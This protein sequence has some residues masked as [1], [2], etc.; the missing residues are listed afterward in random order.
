[1]PRDSGSCLHRPK[2]AWLL[3]SNR[4][5]APYD[6]LM[7][8]YR[9]FLGI[10]VLL[11]IALVGVHNHQQDTG[12]AMEGVL[13][14]HG[15]DVA[16]SCQIASDCQV[17]VNH[18]RSLNRDRVDEIVTSVVDS[19]RGSEPDQVTI[20]FGDYLSGQVACN[21]HGLPKPSDLAAT[22]APLPDGLD[23]R[24]RGSVKSSVGGQGPEVIRSF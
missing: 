11:V 24:C 13:V 22:D 21:L 3:V 6:R 7:K 14:Q 5:S 4:L 8:R 2:T 23:Q 10:P 12:P 9:R 18:P 1:M 15:L 20:R 19:V 17:S 16:W